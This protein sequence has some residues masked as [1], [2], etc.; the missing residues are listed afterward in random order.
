MTA[1]HVFVLDFDGVLCDS[2]AE[3]ALSAYAAVRK[4][5]PGIA[6]C[7]D[8]PE[9][10]LTAMAEVRPVIESGYEFVLLCKLL[11]VA[12]KQSGKASV[13]EQVQVILA[14]WHTSLLHEA[15]KL[16]SHTRDE[17]TH[18]FGAARDAWLERD[19][20]D[21]AAANPFYPGTVEAVKQCPAT[22]FVLTTKPRRFVRLLLRYAGIE[23]PDERVFA[24]GEYPNKATK[25]HEV[26]HRFPLSTVHFVEDRYETLIATPADPR[27]RTYLASWGYNTPQARAAVDAGTEHID[28]RI[29][30]FVANL[31]R[32]N[33]LAA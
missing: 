20:N 28:L 5:W 14:T 7:A 10:L 18:A 23:I 26:L 24:Q 15:L 27:L 11:L 22:V 8:A 9:W 25:V 2:C 21:W 17:L 30:A 1:P 13:A 12:E 19:E 3:S 16:S 31:T 33:D 29:E 6:E 32:G 4:L